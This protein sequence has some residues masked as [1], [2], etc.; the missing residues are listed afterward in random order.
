MSAVVLYRPT[1][2]PHI[3]LQWIGWVPSPWNV[4][5]DTCSS[6][7]RTMVKTPVSFVFVFDEK[8]LVCL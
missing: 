6:R 8:A 1:L 7:A 3:V 5:P 4:F 2:V